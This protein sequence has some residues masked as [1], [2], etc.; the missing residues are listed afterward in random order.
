MA[1]IFMAL[2]L[3]GRRLSPNG[4][5]PRFY[6][7][8]TPSLRPQLSDF[9]GSA[10][11][12]EN[13]RHVGAAVPDP[14]R[15]SGLA[16]KGIGLAER[17]QAILVRRVPH[18]QARPAEHVIDTVLVVVDDPA[19]VDELVDCYHELHGLAD[20]AR[21]A[22]AALG[23]RCGDVYEGTNELELQHSRLI[24]DLRKGR[25]AGAMRRPAV[26]LLRGGGRH[27]I[28][29][30]GRVLDREVAALRMRLYM[31]FRAPLLCLGKSDAK[32][33]RGRQVVELGDRRLE[34]PLPSALGE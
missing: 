14:G 27:V 2:L 8:G 33:V 4:T 6:S 32:V 21:G 10:L 13:R 18:A 20:C 25:D 22:V 17:L 30:V 31:G 24:L 5:R 1:S 16:G 15:L 23:G 28:G 3:A 19:G 7:A 12:E 29:E 9:L 11:L 26:E 34:S